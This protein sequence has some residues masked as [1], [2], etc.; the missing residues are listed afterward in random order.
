ML[1][2]VFVI[3]F[4]QQELYHLEHKVCQITY[5]FQF[6]WTFQLA[7]IPSRGG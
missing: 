3:I 4:V 5:I 1:Q 6:E 2:P 7:C